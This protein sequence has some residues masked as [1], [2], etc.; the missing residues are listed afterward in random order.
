MQH[1][2][3]RLLF[4]TLKAIDNSQG[5]VGSGFI[6]HSLQMQGFDISEA[7]VGRILRQLDLKGYTER[8]GFKGRKLTPTGKELLA[9]LERENNINHYGKE[10]LNVI[11]VTGKQELLDMLIARKAIESQLAKLAAMYITDEEIL[12]M[13]KIIKRQ[14]IHVKEGISIAD[15]D[16]EFHKIISKAAR[17]RVLDAAMDLIRQHGQ[18]SPMLEYIRKRV[19]STVLL[20]HKSIYE[21]IASRNPELAEKAM[22]NHIENLERDVKKY[23]EIA[24]NREGNDES[25]KE[26]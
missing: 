10:L 22:I 4:F 6:R 1:E 11:R 23:W 2:K 24:Y 26:N 14:E 18:L 17:N 15:D 19:K 5:P 20:D 8:I 16:V 7:T 9:E 13:E 12:E 25:Q 21:A 3:L